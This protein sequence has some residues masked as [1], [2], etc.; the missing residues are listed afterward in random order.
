MDSVL[1][2]LLPGSTPGSENMPATKNQLF[3]NNQPRK[4]NSAFHCHANYNAL[5]KLLVVQC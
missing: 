4:M 3:E 1:S 5:Q 2:D